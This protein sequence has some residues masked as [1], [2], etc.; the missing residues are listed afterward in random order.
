[1]WILL[2]L[3]CCFA[4]AS[5]ASTSPTEIVHKISIPDESL[6]VVRHY[7]RIIQMRLPVEWGAWGWRVWTKKSNYSVSIPYVEIFLRFGALLMEKKGKRK[8]SVSSFP[9]KWSWMM[10]GATWKCKRTF[11]YLGWCCWILLEVDVGIHASV[12]F[13]IFSRST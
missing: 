10:F 1:M 8:V 5:F 12:T 11:P 3:W 6:R 7:L 2:C 13:G 9:Y 4:M